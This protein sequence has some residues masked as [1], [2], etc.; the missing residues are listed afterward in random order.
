MKKILLSSII[1]FL[2]SVSIV[3]FQISCKKEAVADVAVSS[4]GGSNLGVILFIKTVQNDKP[5]L[6][7]ELW[8]ANYDGTNQKKINITVGTGKIIESGFLSPDGKI[9]FVAFQEKLSNN[10][11]VINT[12]SCSPDGNN[13]T[14]ILGDDNKNVF[15]CNVY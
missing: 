14:R 3:L 15:V 12:Y 7:K 4:A 10:D 2:F 13:L 6:S 5:N 11:I 8:T 9:V 1:L